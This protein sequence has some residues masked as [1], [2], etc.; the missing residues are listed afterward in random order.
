[1]LQNVKCAQSHHGH[2]FLNQQS[3]LHLDFLDLDYTFHKKI[4]AR[5]R[6]IATLRGNDTSHAVPQGIIRVIARE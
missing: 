3:E 1:M 5:K 6:P 4:D 2:Y